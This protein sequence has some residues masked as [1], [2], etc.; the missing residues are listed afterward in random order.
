MVSTPPNLPQSVQ[1][2]G[3]NSKVF[4][5]KDLEVNPVFFGISGRADARLSPSHF[6]KER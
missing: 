5:N 3:Y 4:R 2:K 6:V 1:N